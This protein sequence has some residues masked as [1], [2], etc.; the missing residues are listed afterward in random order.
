MKRKLISGKEYLFTHR[1]LRT[2]KARYLRIVRAPASD[3][4]DEYYF[5]CE[6]SCLDPV[7]RPPTLRDSGMILLRPSLV[8]LVQDVP[9]NYAPPVTEFA[10]TMKA[11]RGRPENLLKR[12]IRRIVNE[13]SRSR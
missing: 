3:P 5:E 8:T 12:S 2:L 1:R 10:P 7:V 9:Q 13:I 4:I 11:R 6:I